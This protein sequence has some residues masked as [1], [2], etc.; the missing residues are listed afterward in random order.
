VR[1]EKREICGFN[2]RK[3]G[4]EARVGIELPGLKTHKLL[5]LPNARNAKNA[6][7]AEVGYTAGTR[8]GT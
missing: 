3:D 8:A 1:E 5:I 7:I 6:Q 4:L 2:F